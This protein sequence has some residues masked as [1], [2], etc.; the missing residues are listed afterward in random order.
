MTA[1]I[2]LFCI[3]LKSYNFCLPIRLPILNLIDHITFDNHSMK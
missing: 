2:G 1:A 3:I